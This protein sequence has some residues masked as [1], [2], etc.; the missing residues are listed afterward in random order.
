MYQNMSVYLYLLL[1]MKI[2]HNFFF[3]IQHDPSTYKPVSMNYLGHFLRR[4]DSLGFLG[5]VAAI[6]L[7]TALKLRKQIN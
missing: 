5:V 4:V 3:S 7:H 2:T 6:L 1:F